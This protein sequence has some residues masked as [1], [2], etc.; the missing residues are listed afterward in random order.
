[1]EEM[2]GVFVEYPD[3]TKA[4]ASIECD[5][6]YKRLSKVVKE[7]Y[8]M[9]AKKDKL[10]YKKEIAESL[11]VAEDGV[12]GISRIGSI[13]AT[14]NNSNI[15]TGSISVKSQSDGEKEEEKDDDDIQKL[16]SKYA[17]LAAIGVDWAMIDANDTPVTAMDDAKPSR[18]LQKEEPQRK[19]GRPPND[20]LKESPGKEPQRKRGRQRKNPCS[21]ELMMSSIAGESAL[22]VGAEQKK[23]RTGRPGKDNLALLPPKESLLVGTQ[24]NRSGL[25]RRES[26]TQIVVVHTNVDVDTNVD[27]SR[28]E[29][30][31]LNSD[32]DYCFDSGPGFVRT[33]E[34]VSHT[35]KETTPNIGATKEAATLGEDVH[36]ANDNQERV[37]QLTC[38]QGG[39]SEE[40]IWY[41]TSEG[42]MDEP[43][44]AVAMLLRASDA[45]NE[46]Q[47]RHGQLT[48]L[49]QENDTFRQ[50]RADAIALS[51]EVKRKNRDSNKTMAALKAENESLREFNLVLIGL[52]GLL[53]LP[54][55]VLIAEI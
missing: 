12:G 48:H 45:A 44:P 54:L 7:R 24:S 49:Q 51:R 20:S 34:E 3:V 22:A 28:G 2:P 1:M 29:T 17:T 55:F 50:E 18:E 9:L 40:E 11:A 25:P 43:L 27:E 38:L 41:T 26:Q 8:E 4:E 19:R 42:G 23:G 52:V 36:V 39:K 32:D 35:V 30:A 16:A 46:R 5:V 47:D 15:G 10:R 53:L 6:R 37:F 13:S 31:N 21:D 33:E 14:P